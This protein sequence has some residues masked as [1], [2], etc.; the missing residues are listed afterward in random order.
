ML[1]VYYT[2]NIRIYLNIIKVIN[3]KQSRL[4]DNYTMELY[5]LTSFDSQTN[6]MNRNFSNTIK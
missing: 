1:L 2:R 6:L 5:I 4:H 3:Q